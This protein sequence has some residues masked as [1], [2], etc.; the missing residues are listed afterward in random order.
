VPNVELKKPCGI[1]FRPTDGAL[2]VSDIEGQ[3]AVVGAGQPPRTP[4]TSGPPRPKLRATPGP[5]PLS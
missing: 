2:L 1:T 5:K 4:P 3:V